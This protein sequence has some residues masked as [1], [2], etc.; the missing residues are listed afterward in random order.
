MQTA[1]DLFIH[2]ST[3]NYRLELIKEIG[4]TDFKNPDEL[5]HIQLSMRLLR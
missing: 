5:L 4:Q 2:R 1:K 3:M